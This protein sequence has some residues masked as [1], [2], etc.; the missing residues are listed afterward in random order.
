LLIERRGREML[1]TKETIEELGKAVK[2][3]VVLQ[4][5]ARTQAQE[6]EMEE[7][8]VKRRHIS[9]PRMKAPMR[10][11][12][13]RRAFESILCPS[14]GGQAKKLS[15]TQAYC[16]SCERTFSRELFGGLEVQ[17]GLEVEM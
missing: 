10:R 14:C 7:G 8:R 3:E 5:T 4:R 12:S 6:Q 13:R 1:I 11:F 16:P 9:A 15:I 17:H 2:A